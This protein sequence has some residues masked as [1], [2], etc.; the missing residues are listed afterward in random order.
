MN[1]LIDFEKEM[2]MEVLE[3]RLEMTAS[4]GSC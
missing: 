4:L 2:T 1:N 3:K